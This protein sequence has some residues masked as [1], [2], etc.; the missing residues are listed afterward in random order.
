MSYGITSKYHIFH[1]AHSILARNIDS[2]DMKHKL[3]NK[4]DRYCIIIDS[5]FHNNRYNISLQYYQFHCTIINVR[6]NILVL[7]IMYELFLN[8]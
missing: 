8:M 7:R 3:P 2:I 6:S 4:N 1:I 5:I